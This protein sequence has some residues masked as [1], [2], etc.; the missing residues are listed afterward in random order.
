MRNA[1]RLDSVRSTRS[2][3]YKLTGRESSVDVEQTSSVKFA[4]SAA[5]IYMLVSY[6]GEGRFRTCM[7]KFLKQFR[8]SSATLEVSLPYECGRCFI[9]HIDANQQDLWDALETASGKDVARMMASW[10]QNEGVN[11]PSLNL[12]KR[13]NLPTPL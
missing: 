13:E 4:K 3:D 12:S 8:H 11:L 2:I 9:Q 1:L 7:R 6:I 5:L 10:I